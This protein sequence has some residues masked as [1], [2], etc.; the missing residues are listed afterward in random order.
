MSDPLDD[1]RLDLQHL[2]AEFQPRIRRYLGRLAGASDA[3]DLTQET[4]ARV[5][6]AL[7]AFRG[8][9]SLATWVYRIATNVAVDRTRSAAFQLQARAADPEALTAL[10][11]PPAIEEEIARREMSEC[12]RSHVDRLP[13]DYRAVLVLSEMEELA[14]RQIAEILEISLEAAKMRL[15]RARARLRE[16][17]EDACDVSR[18]DRNE[19]ICEP[20]PPDVSLPG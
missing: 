9:S 11:T 6:L 1:A 14:D 19:V 13:A 16:I 2:Y 7:G 3:D 17:L 8:E 15:H 12:V 20:R 10:G 4:F 18:D 5:G